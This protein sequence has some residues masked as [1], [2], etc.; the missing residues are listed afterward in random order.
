MRSNHPV[1]FVKTLSLLLTLQLSV[2]CMGPSPANGDDPQLLGSVSDFEQGKVF[3]F[4]IVAPRIK[5]D[6][7]PTSEADSSQLWDEHGGFLVSAV[8]H[9]S[10]G[11][12]VWIRSR[13][14]LPTLIVMPSQENLLSIVPDNSEAQGDMSVALCVKRR[15]G[16][17]FVVGLAVD[18]LF[19]WRNS[20][21][22]VF[23]ELDRGEENSH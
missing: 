11:R 4:E 9:C 21:F 22:A 18:G 19:P 1:M 8:H 15:Y 6:S 7:A 17:T 13:N 10:D 12:P 5:N 23:D 14:D 20:S 3:V 2:S 16:G